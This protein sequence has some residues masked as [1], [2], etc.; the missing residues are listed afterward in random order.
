[1]NNHYK[2]FQYFSCMLFLSPEERNDA[3]NGKHKADQDEQPKYKMVKVGNLS[4]I[5]I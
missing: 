5:H 4:L 2:I 3:S 1:M